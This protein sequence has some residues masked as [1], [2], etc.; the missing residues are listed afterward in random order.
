[1]DNGKKK[2]TT[3]PIDAG[4]YLGSSARNQRA[5]GIKVLGVTV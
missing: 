3:D 2:T 5:M 4:E 1:M